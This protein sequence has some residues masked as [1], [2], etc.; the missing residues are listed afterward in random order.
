MMAGLLIALIV[1]RVHADEVY[2]SVDAQGNIVYSDRPASAAAHKTD[3]TVQQADPAEAQRLAKERL[4]LK[5]EDN[6]RKKQDLID[7]RVKAQQDQQKQARCQT[8][9]DEY[10]RLK[11]AGRLY[12]RDADGNRVYYSDAEA[13]AKREAARQVMTTACAT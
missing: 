6:Q 10:Y 5:E 4:L 13:D 7:N 8:A 12:K 11:D 9:R 3:V 2:K 1:C